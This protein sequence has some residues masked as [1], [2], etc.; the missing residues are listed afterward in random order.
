MPVF[1]ILAYPRISS[2]SLK[3]LPSEA[4][5][6]PDR[7]ISIASFIVERNRYFQAMPN[8]V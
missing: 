1:I 3:P 6:W 4:S 2:D 5:E 8:N 7:D